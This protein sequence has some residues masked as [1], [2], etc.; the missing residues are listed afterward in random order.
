M[1]DNNK[2]VLFPWLVMH[3][4]VIITR[5]RAVH[6]DKTAYQ[7]IKNKRP[8]NK[9]L[10]FAEKVVWMMPKDNHR[11]FINSECLSVSQ[12]EQESL[13]SKLLKAQWR[14]ARSL[15]TG[16]ATHCS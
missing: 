8:S 5:Y 3:A 16:N 7:R 13:W 6:E 12:Q 15:K 14:R 11:M 4:G 9:M 2:H 1:I 10:P